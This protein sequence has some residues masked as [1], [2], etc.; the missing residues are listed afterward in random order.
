[1]HRK[2]QYSQHE[3]PGGRK[4]RGNVGPQDKG[5][6]TR[7][8]CRRWRGLICIPKEGRTLL[9]SRGVF[10]PALQVQSMWWVLWEERWAMMA[11][12]YLSRIR[13]F[14]C[15]D[16]PVLSRLWAFVML[17]PLSGKPFPLG[18]QLSPTIPL[19]HNVLWEDDFWLL[20]DI[21]QTCSEWVEKW[22]NVWHLCFSAVMQT[23]T[24]M[25]NILFTL[26]VKGLWSCPFLAPTPVWGLRK[27]RCLLP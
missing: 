22:I 6:G 17:F 11:N 18:S 26:L 25:P 1:M 12:L 4:T 16:T 21:W 15:W 23:S 8:A 27:P 9:D 13:D 19:L 2:L 24:H 10:L 7:Q 20:S 5:E 14:F 3:G